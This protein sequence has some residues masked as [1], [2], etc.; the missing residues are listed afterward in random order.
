MSVLKRSKIPLVMLAV[1]FLSLH[2]AC[3]QS[4]EYGD[5]IVVASIGDARSLVPILASDSAS[6][7]ICGLV[8]N[9]LVKYDKNI[10][11]I[12]DLANDW[13]IETSCR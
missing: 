13:D 10:N 1:F 9:G 5:A 2:A 3:A 6:S 7:D 11:I 12:G 8:F 4:P